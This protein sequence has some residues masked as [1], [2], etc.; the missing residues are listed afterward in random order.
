[1]SAH[2]PG[3]WSIETVPTSCGIC[4][5]IGPFPARLSSPERPNYACVYSDNVRLGR[6]EGD[7]IG[8]ELLA[9]ARLIAAAPDLLARVQKEATECEHCG[10]LGKIEHHRCDGHC[11][12][13]D[14]HFDPC[15]WCA[16]VRALIAKATQP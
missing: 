13:D 16:E 3:P 6:I 7:K 1:V 12:S 4:H 14:E 5:K 15:E 8:E 10:G 11:R 2:T 9:N